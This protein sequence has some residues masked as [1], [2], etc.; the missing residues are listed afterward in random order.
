MDWRTVLFPELKRFSAEERA[1]ALRAAKEENPDLIELVG[2]VASVGIVTWLVGK[3]GIG[4]SA[5][6]RLFAV[7]ASFIVAIPLLAVTAG[8]FLIRRTR[9][10]LHR[11]LEKRRG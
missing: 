1:A 3:F 2:I 9:R 5:G 10:G 4:A 7:I 11:Q 8:P 6:S